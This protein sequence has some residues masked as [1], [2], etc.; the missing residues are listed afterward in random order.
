MLHSQ[1]AALCIER[2]IEPSIALENEDVIK[3]IRSSDWELL[4]KVL[5]TQF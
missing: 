4:I 1:F 5:D 3:A 2:T